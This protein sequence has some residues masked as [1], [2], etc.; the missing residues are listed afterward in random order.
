MNQ[1]KKKAEAMRAVKETQ[2]QLKEI[3][4]KKKQQ[5]RV[6][7]AATVARAYTPASL[8]DKPNGGTK[9][10]RRCRY[11]VLDRMKAVA[12]LT[13]PQSDTWGA[14]KEMWDEK[15]RRAL[16][17]Q[18]GRVFAEE[19]KQILTDLQNASV[20]AL[21]QWMENERQRV[22]PNEECLILPA[23]NYA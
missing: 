13:P 8:G 19:M 6:L 21:S 1:K 22:L 7:A 2:N 20:N 15:R 17:T 10:D 16:D 3:M 14:F 12:Y 18:W 11:E 5:E 4:R 23:I 9:D